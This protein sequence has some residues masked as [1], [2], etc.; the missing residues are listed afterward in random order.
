[1]R[2]RKVLGDVIA[3]RGKLAAIVVV[4]TVSA[5]AVVA[6]LNAQTV[7]KR[8]IAASLATAAAPDVG[9]WFEQAG[10]RESTL[11]RAQNNVAAA[12]PR[13]VVLTRIAAADGSWLPIRIVVLADPLSARIGALHRDGGPVAAD[14]AALLV[15][16]SGRSLL[17]PGAGLRLRR[18]DG[19]VADLPP[20]AFV[21]DTSVA[22]STQERMLYGYATPAVA[23]QLG[24]N[25]LPDLLLVKMSK[26]SSAGEAYELGTALLDKLAAAGTPALRMEV[27]PPTHPHQSLMN[28]ML[29]VLKVL[30]ALAALAGAALAGYL[31]A[32]WMRKETRVV[33]VMK[34]LGASRSQVVAQYL[35]LLSPVALVSLA[36]ALPLGMLAG[37]VLATSYAVTLNI[38]IGDSSVPAALLLNEILLVLAIPALAMFLPILRAARMTPHGAISDA[39]ITALPAPGRWAA[40]LVTVPAAV[41]WTLAARNI[42]RR[43]MRTLFM[44]AGLA[45]GGGLLQMNESDYLSLMSVIDQSLERQAHDIEVLLPKAAPAATL[46]AIAARIPALTA[47]EA[48]RR[49]TVSLLQPTAVDEVK[50][51]RRIGLVAY[52]SATRLFRLPL[53]Q[54]RV[55]GGDARGLLVTRA[56]QESMP[57]LQVGREVKVRASGGRESTI[58]VI[59]LTEEIGGPSLYTDFA[60][61]EALTGLGDASNS[62]RAKVGSGSIEEA[63]AAL[64]Q[65]FL[66]ARLPAAQII[67]RTMMRDALDEHFKVV[68][69]VMR[70]VALAA[71]LIGAIVLVATTSLNVLE[72][73]REIGIL[74]TLGA[75]PRAITRIFFAEGA[76]VAALG[77][78]L[79]VGLSL[80]LTLAVLYAAEHSLLYVSVPLRFSAT[81]LLQ[82]CGGALL[83]MAAVQLTVWW[84]LRSSVRENLAY[85]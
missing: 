25:P 66:N 40:R 2:L 53:S 49:A 60:T 13:R 84:G 72:R 39:G 75:T 61:F 21:H 41:R 38:D 3:Y 32:A 18:P 63:V 62:L 28:A 42:W 80:P 79:A 70:I 64:D 30:S 65:A 37:R 16:Q 77:V 51:P 1:M 71:A 78:L 46:E 7:L 43:P 17:A 11:V 45:A 33:G 69:D 52:P 29:T 12:E 56:A 58:A 9:L 5:A 54:G 27:L 22:P 36:L 83:V 19:V 50:Q 10:A 73:A 15:E 44:L 67:S 23:A 31:I 34:T 26:R 76:V 24:I 74:R 35:A 68:G 82:L 20:P 59:G 6:G 47:A 4:L 48:W 57:W 14:A 85:E 55:P 81:G 8:E